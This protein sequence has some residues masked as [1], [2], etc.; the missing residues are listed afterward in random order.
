MINFKLRNKKPIAETMKGWRDWRNLA[1]KEEPF[2]FWL[3]ETLPNFIDDVYN[4]I[5]RPFNNARYWV[6]CRLFDKYH[7]INT[8]LRPGYADS[9]T[10]ILH[11]MFNLLVDFIEVEKAWIHVAFDKEE[12]RRRK[13]PWWSLGWTRFKAFR[14]IDA[15]LAHLKW[16]MSLDDPTLDEHYRSPL[17]A[18]SAREQLALYDWWKNIRPIRPDAYDASGWTAY[19]EKIRDKKGI[20]FLCD[21]TDRSPEDEAESKAALDKLCEIEQSYEDED[22]EMLIRLIRARNHLWT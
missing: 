13:H 3:N 11:G 6:R 8:G 17:Q 14:D 20:D 21:I 10:R 5:T 1:S 4:S 15:G 2:K 12:R 9:D 7:I 22:T 19:C 18:A 16:E